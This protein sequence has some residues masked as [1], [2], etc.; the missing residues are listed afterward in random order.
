MRSNSS[1]RKYSTRSLATCAWENFSFF[2]RRDST[3]GRMRSLYSFA[4]RR[5]AYRYAFAL[6]SSCSRVNFSF[7]LDIRQ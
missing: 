1:R 7:L 4:S 6:S 5:C 3:S 2:P